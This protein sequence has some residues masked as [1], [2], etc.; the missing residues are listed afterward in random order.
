MHSQGHVISHNIKTLSKI[1]DILSLVEVWL[2]YPNTA[3]PDADVLN[4][5]HGAEEEEHYNG[6]Q[7]DI[8]HREHLQHMA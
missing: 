1:I 2:A 6:R 4:A 5:A 8:I 7:E 3:A